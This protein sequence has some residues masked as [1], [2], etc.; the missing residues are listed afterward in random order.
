MCIVKWNGIRTASTLSRG[1]SSDTKHV[2]DR[3]KFL[4]AKPETMRQAESTKR[5]PTKNPKRRKNIRFSSSENVSNNTKTQ[6]RA[7]RHRRNGEQREEYRGRGQDAS[8]TILWQDFFSPVYT[9]AGQDGKRRKMEQQR[10][11]TITRRNLFSPREDIPRKSRVQST[12]H[13]PY[14]LKLFGAP[15]APGCMHQ[16]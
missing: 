1:K 14:P 15:A 7:M 5:S 12:E 13:L 8:R 2:N 10:K 3:Q 6:T 9:R 11:F 16:R 4:F